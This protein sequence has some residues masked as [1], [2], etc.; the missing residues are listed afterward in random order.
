MHVTRPIQ[1]WEITP[2]LSSSLIDPVAF[3]LPTPAIRGQPAFLIHAIVALL[4]AAAHRVGMAAQGR[5]RALAR[6]C[7]PWQAMISPHARSL[8]AS[9]SEHMSTI[10]TE[11]GVVRVK[12]ADALHFLQASRGRTA[13]AIPA[14]PPP[15]RDPSVPSD[16]SAQGLVTNDVTHLAEGR[17][18]FAAMLSPQGR[19]L[20]DLHLHQAG[21]EEG[22]S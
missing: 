8:A 7:L 2:A 3:T 22:E 5:A 21:P 9:V 14:S 4:A 18:L 20:L 19:L 12:G 13:P 1:R 15:P 11:R 10:L 6:A 16:S 17:P